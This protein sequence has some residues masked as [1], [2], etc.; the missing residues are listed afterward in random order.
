[1]RFT[2]TIEIHAPA[3]VVWR[4]LRDVEQWPQWTASVAS[5]TVEQGR[6]LDVGTLVR[7]KQPRL[8]AMRWTVTEAIPGRRFTWS[9]R[10]PGLTAV[11][12]HELLA[13]SAGATTVVLEVT[14]TG[15]RAGLVG[16][17]SS[18]RT[19]HYLDLEAEGL[20][21]AAEAAVPAA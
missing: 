19:R 5:A 18:R 17:L 7:L 3:A 21:A 13:T 9:T 2:R 1:M 11:A 16:R 14:Q 4:V 20:K 10:S 6:A 8:S 12:S 15:A